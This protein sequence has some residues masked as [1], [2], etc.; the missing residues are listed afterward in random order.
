MAAADDYLT[1]LLRAVSFAA[2]AHDGQ[3]RKDNRTPYVAHVFRV[4][5]VAR[6]VFGL[7]DPRA[8][9]AAVL[10]DTLEDTR[11]DYDDLLELLGGLGH[12]VADWVAALSKDTRREEPQRE[13]DYLAVLARAPWQVKVCKLADLYDNL[14]DAQGL[15]AE[16]SRRAVR[17]AHDALA[18]LRDASF[19]DEEKV[20]GQAVH[21]RALALV[22]QVLA[23]VE[24]G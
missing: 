8:L 5:M 13:A 20:A 12:P 15:S 14:L 6:H 10:H 24:A 16:Q 18:V 4:C 19:P 21:R 2:R 3:L 23:A 9:A 7:D 1:T 11:T 22:E 17:R